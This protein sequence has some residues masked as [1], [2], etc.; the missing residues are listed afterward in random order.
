[1]CAET[2]ASALM[3]IYTPKN[4]WLL[5][6]LN[7]KIGLMKA[8]GLIDFWYFQLIDKKLAK[9][10]KIKEKPKI[11]KLVQFQGCF[12]ILMCGLGLI[13]LV[14]TFE[15]VKNKFHVKKFCYRK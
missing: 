5:K 14:F 15:I 6:E 9:K 3:V 13:F 7:E 2:I 11:L 8:A 4:F 10:T 12:G 1:M